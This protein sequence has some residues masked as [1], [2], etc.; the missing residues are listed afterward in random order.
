MPG[1]A[2]RETTVLERETVAL[3]PDPS[4][5][6]APLPPARDT[7]LLPPPESRPE[8]RAKST[9]EGS[10][11][12]RM[13]TRG[14]TTVQSVEALERD[15][16][17]RTRAFSSL[18]IL[19]TIAGGTGIALIPGGDPLALKIT[20]VACALG[21][22]AM[23][24]VLYQTGS[25][26]RYRQKRTALTWFVPALCVNAAV[27][28]FGVFSP[29]PMI[30]VLGLYF[31][32]LSQ[33]GR[34]AVFAYVMCAS[35]V[36]AMALVVM[37]GGRD[38]GIIRP[39]LELS[40]QIIIHVLVQ[41]VLATTVV[42]AR[43]SRRAQILAVGELEEAVRLAAH[44]QALLLEARD[45]LDRALKSKRGR[46]T[47]QQIS[48]YQLGEVLGRGAMGEVYG[49]V[50]TDTSQPVAIKLLSHA[51]LG[52]RDHVLRF[53]RELRT[54][55]AVESP[56]VVRVLEIGEEPVPYLVMERLE[57]ATLAELLRERRT[58]TPSEVVELIAQIGIGVAAATAR[59]IVHRDLKPQNVFRDHADR[60]ESGPLHD[61]HADRSESRG[62]WKVLDFGVARALQHGE[63]LTGGNLVGTPAY[64][65]PEQATGD[66]VDHRTDLYA[67][68]AI[69][70]RSLTGHQPF[71]GKDLAE[72]LYRVVH[73]R[74]V[75]PTLLAPEL[76][77]DVDRV[78][79]IGMARRSTH[80]FASAE[81]LANAL[82]DAIDGK[83]SDLDRARGDALGWSTAARLRGRL[84]VP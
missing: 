6:T 65:S 10:V 39:E 35:V 17:L 63:T 27:L 19:L 54:A 38:L 74:P 76:H 5:D 48:H 47:D 84:R 67:L 20:L 9:T 71:S 11:D 55:S 30:V 57:G 28:F 3:K 24:F 80:R 16:I 26:V 59:G 13:P 4:R 32:G 40:Q 61:R 37:L 77:P 82:R 8:R 41:L 83:L 60:S 2:D 73:A 58:L 70:Y 51:S 33:S 66:N 49:A 22:S 18:V 78:L 75:R 15:E 42:T 31:F 21:A 7:P 34:M 69:A 50:D 62:V 44:R 46:F 64:M 72:I 52:N 45:E 1:D 29:A 81:E 56:H 43:L 12:S 25:P 14:G 68:A 36:G 79:A 53:F 23:V